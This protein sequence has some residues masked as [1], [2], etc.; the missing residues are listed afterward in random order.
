MGIGFGP[1]FTR[2]PLVLRSTTVTEWH[3]GCW[4]NDSN[5]YPGT[6]VPGY[7]VPK[8]VTSWGR[9]SYLNP[10][11]WICPGT[12]HS[13]VRLGSRKGGF[14][15]GGRT[16]WYIVMLLLLLGGPNAPPSDATA[17]NAD[18]CIGSSNALGKKDLLGGPS[19]SVKCM[20]GLQPS[21][22][23]SH[24]TMPTPSIR[25]GC[26]CSPTK[27][28]VLG[29]LFLTLISVVQG[30]S[31]GNN[32]LTEVCSEAGCPV[33]ATTERPGHEA[34][35]ALLPPGVHGYSHADGY[36]S[37]ETAINTPTWWKVDLGQ[38]NAFSEVRVYPVGLNYQARRLSGF[39]VWTSSSGDN[40]ENDAVQC[41]HHTYD[42]SNNNLRWED[43]ARSG[44][45]DGYHIIAPCHANARY[46]WIS[47]EW[48]EVTAG[49]VNYNSLA[50]RGLQIIKS[51]AQESISNTFAASFT[52]AEYNPGTAEWAITFAVS[53][54]SHAMDGGGYEIGTLSATA[55]HGSSDI[56]SLES[57]SPHFVFTIPD[58]VLSSDSDYEESVQFS[59]VD[60]V[61]S[62]KTTSSF[63][64][65]L[66]KMSSSKVYSFVTSGFA[67]DRLVTFA[68]GQVF[69]VPSA[70]RSEEYYASL[71]FGTIA[72]VGNVSIDPALLL[73]V[74]PSTGS[75]IDTCGDAP[76]AEAFC[77]L[78]NFITG[79]NSIGTVYIPL[80]SAPTGSVTFALTLRTTL[81]VQEVTVIVDTTGGVSRQCVT[82]VTTAETGDLFQDVTF[83]LITGITSP[84]WA[85]WGD[86]TNYVSTGKLRS[87]SL[88]TLG[89]QSPG[90]TLELE[91]IYVVWEGADSAKD[92]SGITTSGSTFD[93]TL[94]C[95][96][97]TI[98]AASHCAEYWSNGPLPR[99]AHYS[100]GA[101]ELF[102]S[103]A[104]AV[105]N[106]LQATNEPT[107]ALVNSFI[108][109]VGSETDWA[110][111]IN[112]FAKGG[113]ASK[114][115]IKAIFKGT[116]PGRSSED[117]QLRLLLQ[118]TASASEGVTSSV[119]HF[120][121]T[122]KTFAASVHGVS[123]DFVTSWAVQI[124][125]Q[126][127][128]ACL[129]TTNLMDVCHSRILAGL[130]GSS[131]K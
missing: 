115:S 13:I 91:D 98:T 36:L 28:L 111:H 124:E 2:V 130:T 102:Y 94:S 114:V 105:E 61:N 35:K 112:Q 77:L 12:L 104:T 59:I 57:S 31:C 71:T 56:T 34:D 60:T 23:P 42:W 83:K 65:T 10:R 14:S 9:N 25:F 7:I 87:E 40:F 89:A 49:N 53:P 99:V 48:A 84:Q 120:K 15:H 46:V 11:G 123:E 67:S 24:S 106:Y 76:P 5:W 20:K 90:V 126:Q 68:Q 85:E 97:V 4:A 128:E 64:C 66:S 50:F 47:N 6:S 52:S 16:K 78:E 95:E 30:S 54:S 58:S 17:P 43:L 74:K 75:A 79:D 100:K 62:I 45:W 27:N 103:D 3:A 110:L 131:S 129:P 109:K 88:M 18:L 51:C 92:L 37:Q 19:K 121:V 119:V 44:V 117:Q 107:K 73:C 101:T 96:T 41:Y 122:P 63:H 26:Q 1:G 70:R 81:G 55:M 33:S 32:L 39:K 86:P 38:V 69:L 80:S 22:L 125:I 93:V 8:V 21:L 29:V 113:L 82:T 118:S 116:L 127:S 72:G 108:T